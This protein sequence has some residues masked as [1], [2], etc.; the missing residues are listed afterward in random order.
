MDSLS[1]FSGAELKRD[2]GL[3]RKELWSGFLSNGVYPFGIHGRLTVFVS[4]ISEE[5]LPSVLKETEKR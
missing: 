2:M 3:P 5:I 1:H 4:V